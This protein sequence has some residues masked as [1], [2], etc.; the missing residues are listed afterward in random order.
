MDRA[1][2]SL[3]YSCR[4]E[5]RPMF[6]GEMVVDSDGDCHR[7]GRDGEAKRRRGVANSDGTRTRTRAQLQPPHETATTAVTDH[8]ATTRRDDINEK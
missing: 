2:D 5:M 1:R 6:D 8:D 7:S 3:H 4:G